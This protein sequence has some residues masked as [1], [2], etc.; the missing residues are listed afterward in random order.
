M[1][2]KHEKTP[3]PP[4]MSPE[5]A[6]LHERALVID[7]HNQIMMDLFRRRDRGETHVF[8]THWAPKLRAGGV[9]VIDLV[10]GSNSPCLAYMTDHILWGM[11]TQIDMLEE[12]QKTSDS[13]KICRS[14]KEIRE[15][16][17]RG[18]IAVLLKVESARALDGNAQE[19]NLALLRTLYRLG[20]RTVC[21]V[22]SGRTMMGDGTG[23]M[24]AQAGLTNFGEKI[25]KEMETLGMPV[26]VCQMTDRVFYDVAA[27]ATKPLLDS[28]SNVYAI[29][30]HPRNLKDERIMAMAQ[31]GGAIGLC[32][33]KEY[34][35]RGA[36]NNNDATIDDL[37]RQI[38][39]IADLTGSVDNICIGSDV[40]EFDDFRNIFN[41]WSPYPGSIEGI[42]TGIPK[43]GII[44]D[45]LR[46]VENM[47]LLTEALLQHGYKELDI[48]KIL[49]ENL[50]RVYAE[51]MG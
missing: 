8:D 46:P 14:V 29:S 22:S 10:V 43:G 26:D 42:Q 45:E 5:A 28:H 13:F 24:D 33:I 30:D 49:G 41:C 35:R 6:K 40:D 7:G 48:R 37:V 11:L 3:S 21:L 2:L 44:L 36:M 51:T 12:E 27:I 4:K 34:L 32:F 25:I 20:L 47:G 1:N 16:V 18:K 31:T 23:E 19:L 39:Y 15:C 50:M 38:D 17:A 9:N